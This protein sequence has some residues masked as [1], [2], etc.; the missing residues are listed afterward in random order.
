MMESYLEMRKRQS[1][2]EEAKK[3]EEEAK[4]REEASKVDDCSIRNCITVVES[5]EE[6]SNEE[7]VKYFGVFK[8][9]Q[10]REIFMSAGPMTRLIWLRTMLVSLNYY[11][12][13]HNL[14]LCNSEIQFFYT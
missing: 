9:V 7:K 11:C 12:Y 14:N 2:E 8:D 3:R 13:Q 1:E 4:K 10:N 6:L 5:M